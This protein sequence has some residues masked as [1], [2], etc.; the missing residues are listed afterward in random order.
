MIELVIAKNYGL[1]MLFLTPLAL[2]ISTSGGKE[3][4]V[5]TVAERVAD[6]LFGAVIAVTVLLVGEWLR[7]QL[8]AR[9]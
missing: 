3:A 5:R 8:P 4:V 2:L 1:A 9:R 7:L 6:T